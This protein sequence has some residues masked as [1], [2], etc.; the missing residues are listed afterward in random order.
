[1]LES[2]LRARVTL[3]EA[4]S[5]QDVWSGNYAVIACEDSFGVETATQ[6]VEEVTQEDN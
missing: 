3:V 6:D 2:E 1:M 5:E 4:D